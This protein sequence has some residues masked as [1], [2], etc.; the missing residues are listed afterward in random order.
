MQIDAK[1]PVLYYYILSFEAYTA[2]FVLLQI[3]ANLVAQN[4]YLWFWAYEAKV[5]HFAWYLEK[6]P[7]KPIKTMEYC[8]L[9]HMMSFYS[10]KAPKIIS[11]R[12]HFNL[13]Q[14]A[15][16]SGRVIKGEGNKTVPIDRNEW[17]VLCDW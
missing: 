14:C 4:F 6:G 12:D 16:H 5:Y 7:K 2:G 15:V 17:K 13:D 8:I 10:R 3:V 1:N 11:E 9:V